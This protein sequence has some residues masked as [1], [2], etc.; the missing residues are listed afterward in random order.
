MN[1]ND[2]LI[3]NANIQQIADEGSKIYE[4]IKTRYEPA[5][6]GKFLAI[7]IESKEVFLAD[8]SSEAVEHARMSHPN[9]IFYV[10]KIGFTA[11]EILAHAGQ[12]HV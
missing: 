2:T 7:D 5:Q 1:N 11:A 8:T 12:R 4:Q 6:N 10:V 9:R 3:K